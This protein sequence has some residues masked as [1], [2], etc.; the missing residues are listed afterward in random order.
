MYQ[1]PSYGYWGLSN[2]IMAVFGGMDAFN[3]CYITLDEGAWTSKG[4][5]AAITA[6]EGLVQADILSEYS[7]IDF[8]ATQVDF[9][10]GRVGMITNGTW[11]EAEMTGMLPDDFEMAFMPIPA[12]TKGGNRAMVS[13]V[14]GGGQIP[15]NCANPEAAKAFVGVM[16]SDAGQAIIAK[17]GSVPI[18]TSVDPD[19]VAD[20]MTAGNLSALKA[21]QQDD[22]LVLP[23]VEGY[24]GD[25]DTELRSCND[26]LCLGDITASE[27]CQRMEEAA[28]EVRNDTSVTLHKAR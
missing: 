19:L 4:A 11:F 3:K 10:N 2:Q 7:G 8:A 16:L 9:V 14:S 26:D 21:A 5:L 25:M 18:S 17:Y 12:A 20:F 6:Q 22:V 15:V 23:F 1:N 13:L 24:Y 28:R 27:Y